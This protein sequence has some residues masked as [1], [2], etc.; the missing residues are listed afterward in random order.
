MSLELDRFG[1]VITAMA[2]PFKKNSKHEID[3]EATERLVEHLINNGSDSLIVSGTTGES[4]TLTHD[5]EIELLNCVKN[6][7]KSLGKNTPVIFGAGSNSTQTAIKM[8]KLAQENGADGLL[9]VTPYY[10]KP[11]QKGLKQH[12]SMIAKSTKLPIILY[13]VPG[14]C[15]IGL[16]AE[17]IIELANEH[18]NIVSLK[19]ASNNIDLISKLR[20]KLKAKDFSIYSGDDSLTLA[21]LATGADGVISVASHLVGKEMQEMIK[22]FK[23]GNNDKAKEIHLKLFPLF[24]GLFVE[25]NPTCLKEALDIVGI[26]SSELREPLVPLSSE[27]RKKLEEIVNSLVNKPSLV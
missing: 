3:F 16:Q 14:R 26:C 8:S 1:P 10:N 9:I 2:T 23:S 5:E 12:F 6:K 17:T 27:Q 21:M 25:P 4:P 13:N 7:I 20:S 22:N 18:S 24:D 15:V 19:E 11:N